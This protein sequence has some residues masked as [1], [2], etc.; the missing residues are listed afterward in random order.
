MSVSASDIQNN[1]QQLYRA[2][3]VVRYVGK[4]VLA[5]KQ[6]CDCFD[7]RDTGDYLGHE[8]S[9][10]DYL[11]L[12]CF[13]KAMRA[14]FPNFSGEV[15]TELSPHIRKPLRRGNASDGVVIVDEIDGTTNTKL[16]AAS[17]FDYRPQ[18]G[19]SF[20]LSKS[21]DLKD[22]TVVAFYSF[23]DDA[24]YSAI[25]A[26]GGYLS[27]R[28]GHIL[29]PAKINPSMGDSKARVLVI[30]YSN[31]YRLKKGQLEQAIYGQK[32]NGKAARVY[33]GS[34]ASSIDLVQLLRNQTSAYIDCR[35]YWSTMVDGVEK[36]AMLQVYDVVA[37]MAVCSGAGLCVTDAR[38][39]EWTSFTKQEAVSLVVAHPLIH[40]K[41]L[42]VIQPVIDSWEKEPQSADAPKRRS[43][44]NKTSSRK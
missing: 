17:S 12:D 6:G 5:V 10:V 34:R 31:S 23:P 8:S 19:V 20:A 41:I 35:A 15:R 36:E 29:D 33:D 32:L 2:E 4:G 39:R 44:T 43:K 22:V 11:A 37:M 1:L 27:F 9:T 14:N 24:V 26:D 18:A 42:E 21:S 25:K 7:V 16:W 30:G 28:N 40:E 13:E 38:G 3:A